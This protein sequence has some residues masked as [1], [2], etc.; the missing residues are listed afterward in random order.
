MLH[1]LQIED[2]QGGQGWLFS[3]GGDRPVDISPSLPCATRQLGVM[4]VIG[5]VIPWGAPVPQ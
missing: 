1:T 5:A 2:T 4:A 3:R